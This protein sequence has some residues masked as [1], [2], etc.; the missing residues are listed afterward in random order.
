M[1]NMTPRQADID[2]RLRDRVGV[3][4]ADWLHA[5]RLGGSSYGVM[6]RRLFDLTGDSVSYESLRLWCAR[7]DREP[8]A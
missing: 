2:R 7:L 8:A 5:Q 3:T 4:L 6:S 1:E